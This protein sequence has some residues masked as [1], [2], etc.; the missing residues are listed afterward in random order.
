M[1]YLYTKTKEYDNEETIKLFEE[2]KKGNESAREKI[3]L[4]HIRFVN[5]I[6][7]QYNLSKIYHDDLLEYGILGLM[8]AIDN[9]DYNK[10]N[11]FT[12]YAT[13][14]IRIKIENFLNRETRG[15]IFPI[16]LYKP[17]NVLLKLE[18]SYIQKYGK[19]PTEKRSFG[20]VKLRY[21]CRR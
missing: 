10:S 3:I 12:T 4:T 18:Q 16:N 14:Y 19:N 2:L 7:S 1:K 6:T 8:E 15:V 5:Y 17:F 13:Y 21:N 9:F 11:C 20:S